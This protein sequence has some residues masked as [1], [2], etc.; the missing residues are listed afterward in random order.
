MLSSNVIRPLTVLEGH[1]K[2]EDIAF[3]NNEICVSGGQDREIGVWDLR[4]SCLCQKIKEIHES[5]INTVACKG[6]Y[7]LS[8][9]EEG[10]FNVIDDRTYKTVERFELE[11]PIHGIQFN[12]VTNHFAMGREYLEIYSLDSILEGHKMEPIF[13]H[14]GMRYFF[15]YSEET[16][17]S[18]TGI[19]SPR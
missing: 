13:T 10:R 15:S 12:P 4:I 14:L 17:M 1:E 3:K 5:D 11:K 19:L 16:Y 2:V 18:S 9:G 6:N 8:G 7:I